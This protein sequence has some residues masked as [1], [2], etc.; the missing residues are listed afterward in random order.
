MIADF[1]DLKYRY[2]LITF[3]LLLTFSL[4]YAQP[5]SPPSKIFT[6]SMAFLANLDGNWDI[7]LWEE[8]KEKARRLTQTPYDEKSPALSFQ[9]DKLAYTTTEGR[10]FILDL[11]T[12]KQIPLEIESYPG[13]W[14]NP[15]FSPDGQNLVC[16]YFDPKEKDRSALAMIDLKTLEP[17]LFLKQF[18]PQSSPSWSP[19]DFRIAYAYTHCSTECGRIIQEIWIADIRKRYS[20]QL[21][22]TSSHCLSPCWSPDGDK[23]AFCADT[24]DNFDIWVFDINSKK[25]VQVTSH[26][27][28]DDS[29]AFGPDGKQIAFISTRSGQRAIWMKNLASNTLH[30]LHPFGD[31][32]IECKDVSWR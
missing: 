15:S 28:L 3:T 22:N 26:P 9:R 12:R 24:S 14:D 2:C 30:E 27:G 5:T 11:K 29:P 10:L 25:L 18:G 19:K 7:F 6:G 31:K 13:K 4:A 32:D 21:L 17:H 1:K 8:G 16:S 23:I 20:R